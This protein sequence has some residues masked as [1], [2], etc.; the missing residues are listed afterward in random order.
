MLGKAQVSGFGTAPADVRNNMPSADQS[1][2]DTGVVAEELR[3]PS[4]PDP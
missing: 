3:Q 1:S 2:C 4:S